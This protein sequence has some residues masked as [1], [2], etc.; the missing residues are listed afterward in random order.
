MQWPKN[1]L[2]K[3]KNKRWLIC[4]FCGLLN[5]IGINSWVLYTCSKA[6]GKPAIKFRP[7]YLKELGHNLIQ[8]HLE[9][10]LQWPTLRRDIIESLQG[11]LKKP[12]P[13]DPPV[14]QHHSQER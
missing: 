5:A 10:R 12:I 11:M 4:I 9:Q 8:E 3:K 13:D 14:P 2:S 6:V 1:N 7:I